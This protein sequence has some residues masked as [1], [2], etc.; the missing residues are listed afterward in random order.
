LDKKISQKMKK[1]K[2]LFIKFGSLNDLKVGKENK[3]GKYSIFL[4]FDG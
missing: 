1:E 4:G 3:M 2:F